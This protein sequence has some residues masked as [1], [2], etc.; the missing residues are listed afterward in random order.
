MKITIERYDLMMIMPGGFPDT[1]AFFCFVFQVLVEFDDVP[2]KERDW[3]SVYARDD[4]PIF[5]LEENLVLA[6]RSAPSTQGTLFPALVRT[7]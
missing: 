3:F 5:L 2:W 4:F 1:K 6:H 7:N